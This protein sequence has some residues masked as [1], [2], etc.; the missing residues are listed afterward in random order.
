MLLTP[1]AGGVVYTR[2]GTEFARVTDIHGGYFELEATGTPTFWLSSA[3]IQAV[4][5]EGVYLSITSADVHGHRL[6]APGLDGHDPVATTG[7]TII[8]DEH[9]LSQ[10]ERMEREL[11]AQRIRMGLGPR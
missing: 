2:D 1:P 8:S 10:R 4:E 11:E 3:Y 5:G 7:D 6:T 9:A